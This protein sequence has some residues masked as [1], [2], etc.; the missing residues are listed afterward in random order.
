MG[1]LERFKID[2]KGMKADSEAF[3]FVLDDDY[4]ETLDAGEVSGGHLN[5]SLT[6]KKTAGNFLLTLQ[7][8]GHATVTCDRCLEPMS[9][10]VEAASQLVVHLGESYSDDGD[11]ITV[12]ADEGIIDVSWF[13][14]E[15]TVLALPTRRVHAEGDCN[16]EMLRRLGA[17]EEPDAAEEATDSRWSALEQLKST[18]KE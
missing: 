5:A 2:L 6:V 4:F 12:P 17:M 13:F 10:F 3:H 7:V 11:D 1:N 8:E 16:P 14:Y 9:Q 18:T 15:L